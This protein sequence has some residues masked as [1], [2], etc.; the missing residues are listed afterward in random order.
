MYDLMITGAGLYATGEG[1]KAA[2]QARC[3]P[4]RLEE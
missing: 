1:A 2:L 3:Y 4:Q